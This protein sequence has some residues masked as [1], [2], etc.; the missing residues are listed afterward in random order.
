MK[1]I[2]DVNVANKRILIRCD[3]NVSLDKNGFVAN[4]LRIKQA[5]PTIAYLIEK[6]AKIILISH[7]KE[8]KTLRTINK[9]DENKLEGGSI[10][11]VKEKLSSLLNKEVYFVNDCIG[12]KVKEKIKNMKGG[13][14]LLLENVRIYKEEKE[15][16]AKFGK[17]LSSLAD[18]YVNDAFSVSH[19]NHT[20]LTRIP[21]YIPG[22][23]GMLMEKEIKVLNKIQ[24]NPKKPIVAIIGGAKVESKISAINY[25]LENADHVL[26]GGKIANMVLIVRNIAFNLPWPKKEIELAVRK[27]DYT[28]PKL[29]IPVDVIASTDI[30]GEKNVREV[31]PAKVKKEEDIFDIGHETRNL[32][33]EIIKEAGTIIW[34]GPLGLFEVDAF[35]GGTRDIAVLFSENKNALK[36]IGGGDTTHSFSELG[37][38]DKIDLVSYG[39]GAMLAYITKTTMPG[40]KAI[41]K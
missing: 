13:D 26:L 2:R 27:F 6:K 1:S 12:E 36:I 11:P 23:S 8:P 7:F 5:I 4:D 16:S 14:V 22:F 34:A 40:L 20:S 31:A 9:K 19:R 35:K 32:Y 17:E 33:G 3:F 24:K 18:I 10:Y 41:E 15:N 29:H 39:G 37:L 25:F 38:L 28:S 30:K 21:F